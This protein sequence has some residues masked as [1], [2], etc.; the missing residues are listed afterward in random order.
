MKKQDYTTTIT[1]DQSPE[2]VFKAINDVREWWSGEIKGDTTPGAEFT[3]RYKNMHKS[4]QR[5]TGFVPDKKVVW[6]VTDADLSFVENK[7]EWVGTDIVFEIEKKDGK[8]ELSFTHVGLVPEF[9]CYDGC[10]GGWE[11]LIEGNLR[12]LITTGREQPDAF[13]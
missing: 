8:T 9:E 6:H 4:T 7:S 5:V 2:E 13:A 1:V 10:S 3:Y 11:A 12:N